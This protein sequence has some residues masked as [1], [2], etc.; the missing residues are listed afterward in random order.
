MSISINGIDKTSTI[1]QSAVFQQ[2]RSTLRRTGGGIGNIMTAAEAAVVF[3]GIVNDTGII[4][5]A[6]APNGLPGGYP[7]CVD[8]CGV[9]VV[10]PEKMTL[11]DAIDINEAGLVLDGIGH[12]DEDGTVV[13]AEREM[14]I[15]SEIL[16]YDC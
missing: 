8:E 13:F 5:H 7:V 10:L 9:K 12:I 16:G 15:V 6:P 3:D 2:F 11:Q 1:D 4:T 14:S